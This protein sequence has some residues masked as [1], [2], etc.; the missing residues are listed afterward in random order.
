MGFD[1]RAVYISMGIVDIFMNLL[2]N[3]VND[4]Y[5]KFKISKG[6]LIFSFEL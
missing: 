1:V 3:I 6:F 2:V 4:K 5:N